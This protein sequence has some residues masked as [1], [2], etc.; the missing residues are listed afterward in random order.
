MDRG[1]N[2][3][4]NG[5]VRK[6]GRMEMTKSFGQKWLLVATTAGFMLAG[7]AAPVVAQE[8][9]PAAPKPAAEQPAANTAA[10]NPAATTATTPP[11]APQFAAS[12]MAVAREVVQHLTIA[13][14][15]PELSKQL[16]EASNTVLLSLVPQRE[17]MLNI[18]ATA[19]AKEM[20]EADL[21]VIATFFK[22]AP[23]RAYVEKQQKLVRDVL[24]AMQ[25]WTDELNR[26][27]FTL[28][29]EELKKKGVVL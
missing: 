24:L 20:S 10:E 23:G 26:T 17:Q 11:A 1:V 19:F 4:R 15:R 14:Q 6:L 8:A 25:P 2:W 21:V 13:R 27:V 16:E 7:F 22:T 18:A 3:L 28:F 9:Q 12:H 5:A 29:R